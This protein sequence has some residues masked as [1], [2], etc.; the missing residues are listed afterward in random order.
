MLYKY[1]DVQM[2][3]LILPEDCTKYG[4]L[5]PLINYLNMQ[6]EDSQFPV[7]GPGYLQDIA[8]FKGVLEFLPLYPKV[9]TIPS[10]QSRYYKHSLRF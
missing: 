8:V 3:M 5:V 7:L 10:C 2:V 9:L 4:F 1:W 6:E